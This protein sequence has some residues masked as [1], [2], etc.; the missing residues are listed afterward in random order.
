[1]QILPS[2]SFVQI[3]AAIIY[4]DTSAVTDTLRITFS[5]SGGGKNRA[6]DSSTL[7]VDDVSFIMEPN[8]VPN[9]KTNAEAVKIY[10]NPAASVLYLEGSQSAGLTFNLYAVSGR[11]AA[12][13]TLTGNDNVDIALLPEGLY[14]YSVSD[15]S[16]NTLQ[17]GKVSVVR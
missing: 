8:L 9:V 17:R 4:N 5:T 6:L 15:S 16:G 12:C 7:Y 1:L 3:K 2:D 13:K 14:F 11:V 10:P